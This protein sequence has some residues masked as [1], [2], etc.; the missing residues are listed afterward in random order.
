MNMKRLK[1]CMFMGLLL[2][3]AMT[4][5]AQDADEKDYKALPYMFVGVQGG[6]QNTFNT[7]FN[8][9][10]TFTPTMSLSFGRMFSPVVGA[11]LHFN[12]V[13][14]KSGVNYPLLSDDGHY[15]YNYVTGSL[16]ALVNLC[17]L[18]GKKDWYPVNL[19]FVGGL[20]ANYA[21]ENY[22]RSEAAAPG[23]DMMYADN[24]DRW[25]F[26]G[27]VGLGLEIPIVRWLSF[28]LEGDLNAR[29]VGKNE[30]FNDDLLQMTAQAGFNF[31]FG[32]KKPKA[33]VEE[34]VIPVVETTRNLTLY[35]QMQN[36]VDDRMNVWMKRLS[37]ES[38]A[39]F[40]NRT[41]E[42]NIKTQRLAYTKEVSTEMANDRANSTVRDLRYNSAS[43]KLGVQF[44]DMPSITL[45]VPKEDIKSIKNA[46]DLK[47]T[48]TVYNLNPG[49]KFEVLYTEVLNPSTGKKYTYVNT[50]DA[51]FVQ[52]DGYM[53]LSAVQQDIINNERLQAVA[54]NMVREAKEKSILS[55]NTTVTVKAEPVSAANGKTDYKVT[56]TYDVKDGF[57]VKDDFGP[58]KYEAE[59]SAAST[60]MLNIIKQTLNED[61]AKYAK[62]GKAV[63]LKLKGS[64]DASPVRGKIAYNGQYGDIKDKTV[65][66]NGKD[67][68][69][70]V[71]RASGIT[72][73]EQLSLVR[74]VSV[75]NYIV[76]NVEALKG[77]KVNDSYEVEVSSDE[78]SQF[79]RVAV[80]FLFHEAF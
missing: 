20:G 11:R 39:D 62:A 13:W 41:S 2:A 3:G 22:G 56:Y 31:K 24:D 69:M 50:Q 68:K 63:D 19:Y 25:A 58:G 16:D 17:T 33:E 65:K 43:Q 64:A 53:P 30:V 32:Y 72:S 51:K 9:L 80:E 23:S 79:R 14:D 73:N 6:V 5:N 29:F 77:M 26:N 71:T 52:S 66:V 12:G 44:T 21:F 61:F 10:K 36:T 67:E 15:K 57:S 27:R 42:E 18:F 59:K 48:N 60:V 1:S 8:N 40:L 28:N 78:G 75:K 34:E 4:V 38:Q 70:T 37:G 74:A 45:S 35:E 49:D 7:E 55:D 76:K 54:T 46:R 47:F